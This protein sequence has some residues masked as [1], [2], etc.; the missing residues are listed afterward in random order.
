MSLFLFPELQ[1]KRSLWLVRSI[2]PAVAGKAAAIITVSQSAKSDIVRMLKVGPEKVHVVY[3]AA[4]PGYQ[5]INDTSALDRVRRKYCLDSPFVFF[6]GTL[7]PRKN[8]CRLIG[9]LARLHRQGR[10][11]RLVLAGQ[12]GRRYRTLLRQIEESGLKDSV[13]LLG[14]VPGED[15]PAIYNLARAVAFPSLYE[16][17]GLPIVESMACGTPVITANRGSMAELG[18]GA[19]FLVDP[20]SEGDIEHG[21][22]RVLADEPLREGLRAEGLLRADRFSWR[23]AALET[24]AIYQNVAR[25]HRRDAE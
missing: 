9:A 3:L 20:L 13:R 5:V 2:L 8:L 14:Y 4:A 17:F 1:S 18:Q 10:R 7:E 15:L 24:I 16:G 6:V 25:S 11:E 22:N 12:P 23:R 19:A 21:L